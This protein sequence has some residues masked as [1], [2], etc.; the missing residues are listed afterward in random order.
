MRRVGLIKKYKGIT[1]TPPF[2]KVVYGV[3]RKCNT[4]SVCPETALISAA[5]TCCIGALG[6]PT[7]QF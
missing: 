5:L 6:D 2:M 7:G 3:V 1:T 4:E